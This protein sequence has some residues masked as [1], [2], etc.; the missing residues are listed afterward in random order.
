MFRSGG[1]LLGEFEDIV[2]HAPI[3]GFNREQWRTGRMEQLAYMAQLDRLAPR[4]RERRL[5]KQRVSGR[6]FDVIYCNSAPALHVIKDPPAAPVILHVHELADGLKASLPGPEFARLFDIPTHFVAA[7]NAVERH[8]VDDLGIERDRVTVVYEFIEQELRPSPPIDDTIEATVGDRPVVLGCGSTEWRK[9]TDLFLQAAAVSRHLASA[10]RPIWIWLGGGRDAMDDQRFAR[11]ITRA[12]L[13]DDVKLLPPVDDPDPWFHAASV[14]ALTSREDPFP[15]VALEAGLAGKP[16]VCFAE[17]GGM[18]ELV[19]QGAG[20][21]VSYGDCYAF[22]S[23]ILAFADDPELARRVGAKAQ[24]LVMENH[25]AAS[26][27][28]G[29]VRLIRYHAQADINSSNRNSSV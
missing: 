19:H 18:P 23:R 10:R 20:A 17:A 28:P 16:I 4:L 15:L 8:L 21:V 26:A 3:S 25:L 24:Q 13:Q 9:G 29:L 11:D 12:A 22:A 1:P 7:S 5:D 6:G 2:G 27:M 14:F